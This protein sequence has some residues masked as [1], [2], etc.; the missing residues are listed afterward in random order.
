MFVAS[1]CG[2]GSSVGSSGPGTFPYLGDTPP[3]IP[4]IQQAAAVRGESIYSTF[5][6]VCHGADL[7]G[8]DDWMTSN[9]D[10]TFKPPPMDSSGHTWHHSDQLLTEIIAN[11]SSAPGSAMV[12]FADRLSDDD[13]S[14][15]IEY[16]KRSW[17]VEERGFQWTVTWQESE[18][19]AKQAH[20]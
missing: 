12:G 11:G 15:V 14:A 4:P 16:L 6:A 17:G 18:R 13:I 5:C 19:N 2:A 7:S 9:D 8:A 1:G 3:P 20:L 10:G